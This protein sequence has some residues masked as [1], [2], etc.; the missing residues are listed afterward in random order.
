MP[1]IATA[2][3][4]ELDALRE[5]IR[6]RHRGI[7]I[8][9]RSDGRPQSSPV[10]CGVD[11]DGRIVVSTYPSRAKTGNARSNPDVWFCILSDGRNGPFLYIDGTGEVL[12]MPD[13]LDG[14]IE[15]YRCISG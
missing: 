15:Y 9:T 5:F 1:R 6:R 4:D 2:D 3:R 14:L 8:T 10:A 7:L 13:A 12:D 11:L